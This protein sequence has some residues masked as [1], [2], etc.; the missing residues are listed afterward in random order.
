MIDYRVANLDVNEAGFGFTVCCKS[1]LDFFLLMTSICSVEKMGSLGQ[2]DNAAAVSVVSR[3][4]EKVL[5]EQKN[6]Q[7]LKTDR[8]SCCEIR[9]LRLAY[10]NGQN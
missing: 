6:C 1:A 2:N 9:T 3:E 4:L 5:T 8:A 10:C 7:G